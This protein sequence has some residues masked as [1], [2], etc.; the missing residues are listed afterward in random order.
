MT[1]IPLDILRAAQDVADALGRIDILVG[2]RPAEPVFFTV[3]KHR[4]KFDCIRGRHALE[5]L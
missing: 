5:V 2:H 4:F 1:P 3:G